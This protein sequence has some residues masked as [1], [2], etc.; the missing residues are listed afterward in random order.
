MIVRAWTEDPI[1]FK[2]AHF[3]IPEQSV[4]PKPMQKPH[5]P[6]WIAAITDPSFEVA[7]V[8][9]FNL[10]CS[11]IYGFKSNR[12]RQLLGD[13]RDA[14]RAKGHNP[15]EREIGALCVVYCSDSTEQARQ[16]FGGPVRWYYR[17]VASLV[18]PPPR[19]PPGGIRDLS[20]H[21]QSGAKRAVGRASQ[22][23]HRDMRKSCIVHSADRRT[24]GE[25]RFHPDSVLDKVIGS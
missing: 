22:Q 8:R 17:N 14:L 16:D 23:W 19:Q 4:R 20:R 25:V 21:S 6:I 7:G 13:Y 24:A 12:L 2:S 3:D 15:D 10:L 9:G 1:S 11:L 5:P 18:A